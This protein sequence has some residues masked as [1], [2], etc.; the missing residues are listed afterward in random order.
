MNS[1]A[2]EDL[3]LEY[4]AN[5][6]A[7]VSESRSDAPPTRES[8]Q[9]LT[10]SEPM[11]PAT[12]KLVNSATRRKP[13]A[14]APSTDTNSQRRVASPVTPFHASVGRTSSG[15]STYVELALVKGKKGEAQ[16]ELAGLSVQRGFQNEDSA[17]FAQLQISS[18]SG[19][20]SVNG[21]MA[22]AKAS[23]GVR[24]SDGSTGANVSAQATLGQLEYSYTNGSDSMSIAVSSGFGFEASIGLRDVDGNGRAE[25]CW[26]VGVGVV[27]VGMCTEEKSSSAP[28][29][30]R[31]APGTDSQ[32][33]AGSGGT[34]GNGS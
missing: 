2:P 6:A 29:G 20:H 5:G 26:K 16:V 8:R 9:P 33:A 12:S 13:L 21:E 24:N 3:D 32:R 27:T 31:G 30:A 4:G 34:S 25:T 28:D 11:N 15:D 1:R 23:L 17:T 10:S 22:T 14:P 7:C 18:R 19:R